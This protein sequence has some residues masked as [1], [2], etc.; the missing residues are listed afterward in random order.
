MQYRPTIYAFAALAMGYGVPADARSDADNVQHA[1]H[2]L[3]G[4][5]QQADGEILYFT[6]DGTSLIS[7]HSDESASHDHGEIDFTATI[8]GTLVYG[9]HRAPASRAMQ[10]KCARQ[11]W[12]GM[13]LTLSEGGT[14][15][16][17]FRGDRKVDPG[18]CSI[19]DSAPVAVVYT[20]ISG[21][22][23]PR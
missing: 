10:D 9:A 22:D 11:I 15:L 1:K 7:R 21:R 19:T 3:T 8:H 4:Y 6:Q 16:R 14:E 17:G 5:W 23:A 12:V 2:D 13:G 18:T 20:R